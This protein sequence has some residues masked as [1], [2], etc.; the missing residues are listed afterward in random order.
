M[1]DVPDTP[2]PEVIP[3]RR[4]PL[5]PLPPVRQG[6]TATEFLLGVLSVLWVVGLTLIFVFGRSDLGA[7]A[8]FDPLTFVM[9]LLAVFLP[10]AVLW[11]G[12]AS[13]R[14]ARIMRDEA[15]RLHA[16][17]ESVRLGALGPPARPAFERKLE[18]IAQAQKKTEAAI[19]TFASVRTAL[20]PPP[21]KI[22]TP[23]PVPAIASD[24]AS[25]ALATEAVP[26]PL[27]SADVVRALNFPESVDD[28]EGFRAMRRALSDR[29]MAQLIQA[30]Q[31]VLTL[32]SQDGIYMDD[33]RPD[34][35]RPDL[36]RRFAQG[37]RGRTISALGGVHDRSSL[38]LAAGRMR[39]DTIFRDAVHHFLRK[40]DQTLTGFEKRA[41]DSELTELGDTRTARAFMLL[42]RVAGT[43]D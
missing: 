3:E 39:T 29:Q 13:A 37:E 23:A 40:F 20:P 27:A 24:Q 16:A 35:T 21:R 7:Q 42:G 8:G 14:S 1:S 12:I 33:L 38:A 9:T 26:P 25:L 5:P 31:D 4:R 19:A 22:G 15:D 17:I 28:T 11:I 34:R 41:T 32:L 18:E 10:V 43:F 30:S 6:T 2:T 36:W